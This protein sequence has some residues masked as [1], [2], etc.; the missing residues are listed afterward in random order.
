[1]PLCVEACNHVVLWLRKGVWDDN[2]VWMSSVM[3]CCEKSNSYIKL[4]LEI[5]SSQVFQE[6]SFDFAKEWGKI[7]AMEVIYCIRR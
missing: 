5:E 7:V 2:I 1:M 3:N 4:V 6:H